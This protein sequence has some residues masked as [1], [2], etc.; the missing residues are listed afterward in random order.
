MDIRQ[1]LLAAVVALPLLELYLLIKLFGALGFVTTVALLLGA[2]SLGMSLL[3]SQGLSTWMNVQRALARG[4]TPAL[5]MLESGLVALGGLLLVIPGFLSD[6]LGL[7]CLIPAS[8]KKLAGYLLQKFVVLPDG[9]T[10]P[11]QGPRVIEGEFKR[12]KE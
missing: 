2:A 10:E 4:E 11:P 1:W 7:A 8:R 12:E 9:G 3:R 5:E 6:I